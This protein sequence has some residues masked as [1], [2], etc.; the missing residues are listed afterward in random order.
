MGFV[1]QILL[2]GVLFHLGIITEEIKTMSRKD[3][4]KGAAVEAAEEIMSVPYGELQPTPEVPEEFTDNLYHG[5]VGESDLLA[6]ALEASAGNEP[7]WHPETKDEYLAG[8]VKS[9]KF[10][11]PRKAIYRPVWMQEHD[12]NKGKT[13]KDK[14]GNDTGEPACEFPVVI[15]ETPEGDVALFCNKWALF[16]AFFDQGIDAQV[17]KEIVVVYKGKSV[18]EGGQFSNFI[19]RTTDFPQ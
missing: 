18:R 14:E 2:V 13:I 3:G 16:H 6:A 10:V 19:V 11:T 8:R 7:I 5:S 15:V 4:K 1:I 9:F 17:G 12:W